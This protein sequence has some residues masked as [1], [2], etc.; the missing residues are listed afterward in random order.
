[1]Q[2]VF[3]PHA[4]AALRAEVRRALNTPPRCPHNPWRPKLES[5]EQALNLTAAVRIEAT[6]GAVIVTGRGQEVGAIDSAM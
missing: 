5:A 2:A 1:L 6:G 4:P 3:G